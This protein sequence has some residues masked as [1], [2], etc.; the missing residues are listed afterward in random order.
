[1][2][3]V[4]IIYYSA[5]GSVRSLAQA[6]AEGAQKEGAAVR[7]RRVAELAPEAAINSNPVWAE[8]HR[9]SQEIPQAELDDLD[10]A[11]A[12]LFGSPTR[13]GLPAAQLKQFLDQ[14]GGLW[15]QGK[16]ADKVYASFTSAANAHGGQESTI[17]AM[18]N[19]FYHWGGLIAAP[20]YTDPL[21]FAA[22]RQPLR[23][24]A[25]VQQRGRPAGPQ[26]SRG[27]PLP[28]RPRDAHR[29]GPQARRLPLTDRSIPGRRP[30]RGGG[31]P[32]VVPEGAH[33]K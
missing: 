33:G 21:L 23:P 14:T 7:L 30:D 8:N 15:A 4:A 12:V 27:R 9:T 16:L 31:P 11:D 5:T 29:R 32:T 24:V 6:I 26:P 3:R 22:G 28:G 18:N 20:G 2:T 1:M 17:L 25:P 13:Y 10:W 19:T